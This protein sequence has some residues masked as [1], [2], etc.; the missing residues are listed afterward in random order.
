MRTITRTALV[1]AGTAALVGSMALPA[2][3]A[4]DDTTVT[5][6]EVAGGTID[7]AAPATAG[8]GSVAVGESATISLPGIAVTDNRA[9]TASWSASV[10][11]TPLTGE[12]LDNVLAPTSTS[13]LPVAAVTTGDPTMA[14]VS[15]VDVLT[16]ADAGSQKAVQTATTV[17]GN[18]TATWDATLTVVTPAQVLADT[19]TSTLTHSVL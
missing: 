10:H 5:T 8:S 18:N 16:A 14:P 19:Y 3:A 9:G 13:Y 2:S 4:P 15:A 17:A 12:I 1:L 7:I 6:V 11:M